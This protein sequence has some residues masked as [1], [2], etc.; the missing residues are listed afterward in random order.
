MRGH[1]AAWLWLV[2]VAAAIVALV[3]WRQPWK[4]SQASLPP[5]GPLMQS[6]QSVAL[7][8]A[9]KG[10]IPII[11]N[12]LG[13][14]TSLASVTMKS[15]ISGYLTAIHF[16][17]GQM[18]KKGDLLAEIDSRTYE[19]QLAQ[20]QGTLE[21]DQAL[22]DNARLDLE[23]YRR[24]IKL[25]S[26]SKQTLDTQA[27]TVRQYEGTV[28]ADQ[29]EVDTQKLNLTYCRIVSPVDG[30]IGLR[31]VDVGTYVTASDTDGIVVVTQLAPISVV[32]TLPESSLRPLMKRLQ[33]GARI[34]V[35]A[36]D[37]TNTEKLAEGTL[38]AVDNKIDTTTGTVKL[39]AQFANAD[40]SLFPNQF[41]NIALLLDTLQDVVT[42]PT[43]AVQTGT[44]G[45]FVYLANADNTVSLRKVTIGAS[46]AGRIAVLSGLK[47]GDKVVVDGADHLN[48]GAKIN[49]PAGTPS[50]VR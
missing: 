29:A 21:K 30:R 5:G 23:R 42:A 49:V 44:P 10:N 48:D 13:T 25:D 1:W 3:I 7:G 18:V 28:R 43:T 31:Q 41:V 2:A 12:S 4:I 32:F 17:E 39:R 9:E 45:T 8:T 26:T 27:A 20:Y 47:E 22:L 11:L 14:V 6:V 16:R 40:Q 24:L 37:Q 33:T 50:A 38:E 46:A 15:Q 19:A 36:Y 35:I 34:N